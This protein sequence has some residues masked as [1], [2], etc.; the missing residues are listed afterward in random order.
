MFLMLAAKA[1]LTMGS[2]DIWSAEPQVVTVDESHVAHISEVGPRR[3]M[4][5]AELIW[6]VFS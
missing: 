4:R 6:I 2:T 1:K 5:M 3:K